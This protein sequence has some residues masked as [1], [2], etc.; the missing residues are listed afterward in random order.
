MFDDSD[1][2]KALLKTAPAEAVATGPFCLPQVGHFHEDPPLAAG[3]LA[4][5]RWCCG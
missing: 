5:R 2:R 3:C 4:R 1:P